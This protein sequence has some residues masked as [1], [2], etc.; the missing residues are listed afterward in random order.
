MDETAGPVPQDLPEVSLLLQ[1]Q[2]PD[3]PSSL[4]NS[5]WYKYRASADWAYV[6]WVNAFGHLKLI[7]TTISD[8]AEQRVYTLRFAS[9]LL[10]VDLH[11][12]D[13]IDGHIL[14]WFAGPGLDEVKPLSYE[15]WNVINIVLLHLAVHGAVKIAT[16][17]HGIVYP[18]WKIGSL[19]ESQEQFEENQV[20][21]RAANTLCRLLLVEQITVSENDLPPSDLMEMQRLKTRR[22]DVCADGNFQILVENVPALVFIEHNEHVEGTFRD[23]VAELR[24]SLFCKDNFRLGAAR[25]VGTVVGAFANPMYPKALQESMHDP[26]IRALRLIFNDEEGD[27][28]THV[29]SLLSPW[30]LSATAAITSFV[31]QQIGQ[32]LE[33]PSTQEQAKVELAKLASR[34]MQNSVTSQEAE[35]VSEMAKGVS[36]DVAGAVRYLNSSS[37]EVDL[38]HS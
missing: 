29:T 5:L 20:F 21:L 27:D 28:R 37:T 19:V 23:Q 25:N 22:R 17:L 15:S 33:N 26:L 10:H 36:G 38:S 1:D 24:C 30:K 7:P 6:V 13:G 3:T 14:E 9:F 35:F 32:R 12:A 18:A 11:S 8:V 2:N 16:L 31:L 34:L 4:A